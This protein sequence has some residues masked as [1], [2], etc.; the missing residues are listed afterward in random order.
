[1]FPAVMLSVCCLTGL[2]QIYNKQVLKGVVLLVA[3][4]VL[5]VFSGGLAW[6]VT[7]PISIIDAC[8]IAQKLNRGQA[9]KE[10]EWF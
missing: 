3:S 10:W 6:L 1:M 4:I 8:L 7:W 2:A 9:V 5:G